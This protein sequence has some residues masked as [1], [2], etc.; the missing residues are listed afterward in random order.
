MRGVSRKFYEIAAKVCQG[1]SDDPD[2][3]TI[4]RFHHHGCT[5]HEETEPR[6]MFLGQKLCQ[7]I[8]TP[9]RGDLLAKLEDY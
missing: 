8:I 2:S 6:A 9:G 4:I 7:L 1:A 3:M 5:E